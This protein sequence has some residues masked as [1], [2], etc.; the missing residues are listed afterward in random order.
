VSF[1]LGRGG[2]AGRKRDFGGWG[3]VGSTEADDAGTSAM[4]GFRGRGAG[5]AGTGVDRSGTSDDV[6]GR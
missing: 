5:R 2:S 1:P 4:D 6:V 3:R